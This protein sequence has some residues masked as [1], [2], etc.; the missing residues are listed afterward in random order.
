VEFNK[1]EVLVAEGQLY[2]GSG[3]VAKDVTHWASILPE[4]KK[5]NNKNIIDLQYFKGKVCVE[6]F[7]IVSGFYEITEKVYIK[8]FK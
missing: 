6:N 7:F 2:A 4:I 8:F 1:D 3:Y 5:V